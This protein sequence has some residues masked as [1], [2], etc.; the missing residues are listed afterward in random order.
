MA[1]GKRTSDFLARIQQTASRHAAEPAAEVVATPSPAS[2]RVTGFVGKVLDTGN[3]SLDAQLEEAQRE[4]AAARTEAD[5]LKAKFASGDVAIKV[6]PKRVRASAYADRHPKA[7]EGPEFLAFV[8][9]IKSTG[10]NTEPGVVRPIKDDP[11]F[12]YELAAAHRRHRA[13]LVS[14]LEFFTFVRELSDEELVVAME[15]ENR[16]R[17]DLSPF[18]RGRHYAQLLKEGKFASLRKMA[19]ALNVPLT[20]MQRLVTYGDLPEAVVG[21]F[22]DPRAIRANWIRPLLEAYDRNPEAVAQ[23]AKVLA[24]KDNLSPTEVY[25]RLTGITSSPSIVAPGGRA[26]AAVRTIHDRKA[27]ILYKDAPDELIEKL[28]KM[29]A[30]YHGEHHGDAP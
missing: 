15:V 29:I 19:E 20:V 18:E 8:D 3:K 22:I 27:I 9:E 13:C 17:K 2:P 10:G 16:G 4:A 7:F 24:G 12:D 6:D 23:E 26:L 11:D 5:E 21:A 14:N 30:D 1:T 28:T 25:K